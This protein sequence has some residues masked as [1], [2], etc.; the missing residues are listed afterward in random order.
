MDNNT[1]IKDIP[2]GNY[3]I[4]I[5]ISQVTNTTADNKG[6]AFVANSDSNTVSVLSFTIIQR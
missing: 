2:V 3:P 5:E 6:K 4:V 1:K